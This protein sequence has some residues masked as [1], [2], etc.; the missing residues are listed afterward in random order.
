MSKK[1]PFCQGGHVRR[2]NPRLF[3]VETFRV[4]K[5]DVSGGEGPAAPVSGWPY[6]G[7]AVPICGQPPLFP[8]WAPL[9]PYVGSLPSSA[10]PICPRHTCSLADVTNPSLHGLFSGAS[11][12]FYYGMFTGVNTTVV[13]KLCRET[14]LNTFVSADTGFRCDIS[15]LAD[16]KLIT[17]LPGNSHL[18]AFI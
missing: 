4:H 18:A 1:G 8:T 16:T 6:L 17:D 10:H 12:H 15:V 13:Y 7:T 3:C 11:R 9:L 2:L 5:G 14:L